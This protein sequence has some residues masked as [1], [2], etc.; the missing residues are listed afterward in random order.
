MSFA[1]VKKGKKILSRP[2][3]VHISIFTALV[4]LSIL[5]I[6]PAYNALQQKMSFIRV[7][8]IKRAE[9]FIGREIRYSSI[10]PMV[11]GFFEIRDLAIS[12]G[13]SND[14]RPDLLFIP[15]LRFSFSFWDLI[16][17]K[18]SSVS[19]VY[20]DHP[21]FNMDLEKDGDIVSLL[22]SLQDAGQRESDG[23]GRAIA[24]FLPEQPDF[25]IKNGS[26]SLADG[27]KSYQIQN[28]SLDIQGNDKEISVDGRV[29]AGFS[30]LG[31]FNKAFDIMTE[32]NIRGACSADLKEGSAEIQIA[33]FSGKEGPGE[34]KRLFDAR[35][36][37]ISMNFQNRVINLA[38]SEGA[39]D[40]RFDYNMETG[41][42]AVEIN[43]RDFPLADLVVLSDEWK[44]GNQLLAQT[45]TGKV[46]FEREKK[47][48]VRYDIA[49]NGRNKAGSG[50]S[51]AL[52]AYGSDNNIVIDEFYADA[53]HAKEGPLYGK[54]TVSGKTELP[55][56]A[57]EGIV[58]FENFSLTG[59]E[60][61]NA[62]LLVSGSEKE[63]IIKGG[64]AVI[65]RT[66]L[67]A[68][69]LRLFPLEKNMEISL[70]ASRTDD[71]DAGINMKAVLNYKP[72]QL[73][74]SLALDSFPFID[75][76]EMTRPFIKDFD[77]PAPGREYMRN[78]ALDAEFF[79][80]TDFNHF[81][82]NAPGVVFF[83]NDGIEDKVLS[84]LS[85]SGTDRQL[86]LSEGRSSLFENDF[87]FSG[88]VNYSNPMDLV[89]S[90]SAN[91]LDMSWRLEGGVL[92]KSQVSVRDLNGLNVYG[93]VSKT[94]AV[95]GYIDCNNFPVPVNGKPAYL[96]FYISYLYNSRDL[97]SLDAPFLEIR[98]FAR[99]SQTSPSASI[100][101]VAGAANQDGAVFKELVYRDDISGLKGEADISWSRDF[102]NLR[103][104]IDM[105]EEIPSSGGEA[106]E[107]YLIAGSL[108]NNHLDFKTLARNMRLDRFME[109]SGS[110]LVSGDVSISWD[111]MQS[112][113]ARLSL[114]SLYAKTRED[115]IYVSAEASL[116]KDEL[117]IRDIKMKYNDLSA[118]L[119]SLQLS[120]SESM[121]RAD[122]DIS[123]SVFGK[124]LEG[125]IGLNA[126][127]K[128][129]D[130]WLELKKAFDSLDGSV[131]LE[132]ARYAELKS[133]ETFIFIFNRSGGALSVS[134]GPKNMLRFEMDKN[135]DFFAGLSSPFP[136]RSSVSGSLKDGWIDAHCSDF[137][138][139][140]PAFWRLLPNAPAF[141][142]AGGYI[143][144]QINIR[145]PLR[146]PE[147]FGSGRGASFR[148]RVP[149]YIPQDIR[150]APF[151]ITAEGNE[152]YFDPVPVITGTGAGTVSGWFQFDQWIPR[153]IGLEITVPRES[154]IPY[155]FNI[156]GFLAGG[157]VSGKL[158]LT[159]D[160]S[161]FY[162]T[163]DLF[164]NNAE[165]GLDTDAITRQDRDA[166]TGSVVTVTVN[167]SITTGPAVEFFWPNTNIPILRAYPELG[168]V[169]KVS[170]NTQ[171]RHFSLNS[172]VD[173]RSGEIFYFERSFF[174]RQGNLVFR[175]NEQQ[176]SPR[177]NARA[178]IRDRTDDGPVTISMI[179]DN[180]PL[181]RFVPRFEANPSLTQL[182][183]Y[184]LLG[185]NL[186][187]EENDANAI[188]R[189]FLT[190]T[191]DLLAQ[192][193]VVRQFER[194][195][196]NFL[197]L[198]L[199]S[200]RTQI[201]QNAVL[202]ITGL[203][204]TPVDRSSRVVNY[205]DNTA[206]FGGKYIGQDMFIQ[207]MLSMR[208]DE[209]QTSLGG[210]K[211]EPDFGFEL[212]SPFFNIRW[213]FIPYHPENW[214]VN[215]NSI[216]LTWSKSF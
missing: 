76:V 120:L 184:S 169:V 84:Y 164:A 175:E 31:F 41:G 101:R 14:K 49:F 144:A 165:M 22:A 91:Y 134:G 20:I 138:M 6:Q 200:V 34:S 17:G 121:A 103:L 33:S 131:R 69:D 154:P 73:E 211:I 15:K 160:N 216:T 196:R 86:T 213:D 137:F 161:V 136:I 202:N 39:F 66:A 47:G 151:S 182:E 201:L 212:Q 52:K 109:I 140:M 114:S 135:G 8:L 117:L 215:D 4:A 43:C 92:D 16:M 148:F 209:N 25:K 170:A 112:F 79:F 197:H 146:D 162:I 185:L 65:G 30:R 99:K 183:I 40:C 85:F 82:Y 105:K 152:M 204:Q 37:N 1:W 156:T 158:F 2:I 178:E 195:I 90:I 123:G 63:I 95:S 87:Y 177:I 32:M 53:S 98:D 141:D 149:D 124:K 83:R 147:F 77:I 199:F 207:G 104:H 173:I 142:I 116:S 56:L 150:P 55:P 198:D 190:S 179:I 59:K 172:D 145:G 113:D 11:F 44:G 193:V 10:R 68:V 186:N 75:L 29:K 28:L 107:S 180:E 88:N 122:A 176:F 21:A 96:T 171:D 42:Q 133:S 89:F 125:F 74:A 94:G 102:A 12:S 132:N 80:M 126:N 23:I 78:A 26:F 61:V 58:V 100:L 108:E 188:Q 166:S 115:V 60:N 214:W 159:L 57:P 64:T 54:L 189:F 48:D 106:A 51:F 191:A 18:K 119:P 97:W 45:V 163:G 174:I 13:S 155:S 7:S 205:F 50:D 128:H 9:A 111:S 210:L 71:A 38:V 187:N 72:R 27:G 19:R 62:A 5:A 46:F 3:L 181:L 130:S 110:V 194:Q 208:Y 36:V 168:T 81:M 129:I 35:P 153:N 203:S 143:T 24:E 192:F 70:S 139:D 206:V 127:F 118:V 67:N 157:D 167:L 93:G